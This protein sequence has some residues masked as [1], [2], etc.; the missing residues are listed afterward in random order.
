MSHSAL[1]IDEHLVWMLCYLEV[2]DRVA[3]LV[4][5]TRDVP[6][7]GQFAEFRG[8]AINIGS[9]IRAHAFAIRAALA[10]DALHK[11]APWA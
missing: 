5:A 1:S 3:T 2:L 10:S 7:F 4:A 9:S 6:Q 8:F 11:E